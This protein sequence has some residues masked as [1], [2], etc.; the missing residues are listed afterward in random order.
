MIQ[1]IYTYNDSNPVF[2]PCCILQIYFSPNRRARK[3]KNLMAEKKKK[4]QKEEK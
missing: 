2:Y 1:V 3:R 4:K